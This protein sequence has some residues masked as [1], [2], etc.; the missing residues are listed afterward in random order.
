MVPK[1]AGTGLDIVD[2]DRMHRSLDRSGEAFKRRVFTDRER[3]WADSGPHSA[4]RYSALFAAKEACFK[5]VSV[6]F[7]GGFSWQAVE[8]VPP[9]T[10]GEPVE[11]RFS[12]RLAE[13]LRNHRLILALHM[14]RRHA[15]ALALLVDRQGGAWDP[16]RDPAGQ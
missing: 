10:A 2:V 4:R 13:K 8:V 16:G 14:D 3:L 6:G 11:A 12:G 7:D 5:A 1:I 15:A 9:P